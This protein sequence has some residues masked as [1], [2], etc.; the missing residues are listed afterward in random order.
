MKKNLF[1]VA[2]AAVAMLFLASC[3][4]SQK[5]PQASKSEMENPYGTELKKTESE[6]YALLSP[7]TRS[8]GMG[9]S[10]YESSA[11]QLAE[12][13]A[14]SQFS[15][16]IDAAVKAAAKIAGVDYDQ[17]S[18]ANN[19]GANV[20]DESRKQNTYQMSVSQNIVR[21]TNVVKM[22]KFYGKDRKYTIFV[23]IEYNG[24]IADIVKQSAESLKQRVS[25]TDREKLN[26]EN[27]KFEKDI[28]DFLLKS[29]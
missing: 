21:Q 6:E 12:L 14:R 5:V 2:F 23:C 29:K 8:S 18:G 22:N 4:S 10:A 9:I 7:A 1:M 15:N 27:E 20:S 13:D 16:K 19:E 25:D 26:Q 17:Y 11:R 3:G 28:E 24:A